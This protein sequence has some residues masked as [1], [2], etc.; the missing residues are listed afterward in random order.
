MSTGKP[1]P[2]TRKPKTNNYTVI[3]DQFLKKYNLSAESTPE[4]LS[5]HASELGA[6]L[7]DWMARRCVK[8][9]LTKPKRLF[10]Q[11]KIEA[12]VPDKR[13][14]KLTIKERALH[15]AETGDK[16]DIYIHACEIGPKSNDDKE[17]VASC[18]RLSLFRNELEKAGIA[19]EL[20]D[21]Y[22]KDPNVTT[23]SNQIQKE[24][25]EQ[26]LADNR[27]RT[28]L[29]FSLANVRKR[30]QNMDVSK[31]P[32]QENLADVIV[33][34]S[35]RPAEVRSL[36]IDHYE[37]DPSASLAKPN[38]PA[39]YVNGYSWY[40][41]GYAKNKGENKDNPEPRPFVSMEKDPERART[42][43]IWIQ[44][45]I[46]AGKLS[47]PT[48]SENGKRNTRAFSKFLKPNKITPKILRK[49]GGKHACRVHGG[50]NAT[51]QQLDLL[52]R[53][54]LRHKIV[55]HDAG[56]NY[57]IRDTESEDNDTESDSES[58]SEVSDSPKPQT[59]ASSPAPQPNHQKSQQT[60]E[61]DSMLA[62]IDAMLAEFR[63]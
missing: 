27:S 19:R 49:I 29:H 1:A 58:V 17:T 50:L 47:D 35:M 46:K 25:T 60:M 7:P 2:K 61:M 34:L 44:E 57:A 15:C 4:Q 22:A 3:L 20:I 11:E 31:I 9:A 18:S 59:Q 38:L 5:E 52:N 33:M 12:L 26:N 8:V 55:R 13:K 39:W 21:T 43:L 37:V 41:T 56:K 53:R 48:F 54:A 40:C 24:R 42:L 36:Q 30:I 45:A 32:T 6:S 51:H 28:P 23:T 63:K 16:W 14:E 62:E 10:S